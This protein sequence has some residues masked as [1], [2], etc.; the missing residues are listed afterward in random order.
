M[1]DVAGSRFAGQ[2]GV[3][4][5][6][7]LLRLKTSGQQNPLAV[8]RLQHIQIDADVG[9]EESLLEEGRFSGGLNADENYCLHLVLIPIFCRARL[10]SDFHR[11]LGL[12]SHQSSPQ[13]SNLCPIP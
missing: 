8:A 9:I 6:E 10:T 5:Q 3:V 7:W 12:S 11:I 1:T 2:V 4:N 13:Q